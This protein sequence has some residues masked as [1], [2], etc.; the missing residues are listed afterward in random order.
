[1]SGGIAMKNNTSKP[2]A[3]KPIDQDI[4]AT[5]NAFKE[6]EGRRYTGVKIGRGHKWYYDKGEWK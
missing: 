4:A 1:M 6:F 5:Y 3:R 2:A